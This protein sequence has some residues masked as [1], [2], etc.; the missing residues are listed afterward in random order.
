[1]W[2]SVSVSVFGVNIYRNIDSKL[3]LESHITIDTRSP[4]TQSAFTD[5]MEWI[6]PSEFP[7]VLHW[8]SLP[9]HPWCRPVRSPGTWNS[10]LF[11]F[12]WSPL[13]RLSLPLL[14]VPQLQGQNTKPERRHTYIHMYASSLATYFHTKGESVVWKYVAREEAYVYP[15]VC[16]LFGYVFPY[17]GWVCSMEI[18]MSPLLLRISILSGSSMEIRC[19]KLYYVSMAEL[20]PVWLNMCM[21]NSICNLETTQ[22]GYKHQVGTKPVSLH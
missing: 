22:K 12:V 5:T 3:L 16:L 2:V 15:Y 9:L 11:P 19:Q 13:H 14:V 20:T 17:K 7:I 18:L 1:M 10:G 21:C 8:L 6:L 4:V